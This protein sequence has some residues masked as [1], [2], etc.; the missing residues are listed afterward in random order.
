M[1]ALTRSRLP[2]VRVVT[3][4]RSPPGGSDRCRP[5]APPMSWWAVRWSPRP[6]FPFS[7]LLR[8]FFLYLFDGLRLVLHLHP[9]VLGTTRSDRRFALLFFSSAFLPPFPDRS[10]GAILLVFPGWLWMFP[11]SASTSLLDLGSSGKN[12]RWRLLFGR[13]LGGCVVFLWLFKLLVQLHLILNISHTGSKIAQNLEPTGT[14]CL[15]SS[16]QAD[17]LLKCATNHTQTSPGLTPLLCASGTAT[18]RHQS[19]A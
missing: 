9:C 17:K 19:E 13:G 7:S 1:L 18:A 4:S 8:I 12:W 10:R 14:R 15:R 3:S 2:L 11:R 16:H 6:G 5:P